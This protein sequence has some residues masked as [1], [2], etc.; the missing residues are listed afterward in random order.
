[1][2]GEIPVNRT[3]ES[4]FT[5]LMLAVA[6]GHVV[7]AKRVEIVMARES[8]SELLLALKFVTPE[9]GTPWHRFF[10]ADVMNIVDTVATH[11]PHSKLDAI[12]TADPPEA[13]KGAKF[14]DYKLVQFNFKHHPA[15]LAGSAPSEVPTKSTKNSSKP[16]VL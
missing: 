7:D 13:D 2:A 15:I 5:D 3:K 4:A 1:M 16:P 8:V 10:A 6:V 12:N 11:Y 9:V 14:G